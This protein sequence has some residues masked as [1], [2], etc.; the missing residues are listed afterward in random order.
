MDAFGIASG[1]VAIHTRRT[2]NSFLRFVQND[3]PKSP[4]FTGF[5]K[6]NGLPTDI[7]GMTEAVTDP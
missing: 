5:S 7:P 3:N 2:D 6:A 4:I 1:L